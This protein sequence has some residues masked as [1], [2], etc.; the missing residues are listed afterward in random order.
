[1][2]WSPENLHPSVA[3]KD[4]S[5][6]QKK[7]FCRIANAMLAKGID[8][9]E[10]IATATKRVESKTNASDFP[11]FYYAKHMKPGLA[12]YDEETILVDNDAIKNM[13]PTMNGRPVYI[14]HND[15]DLETMKSDASGYVTD[16]FYNELDGCAWCKIMI[17]DDEAHDVIKKNWSVSNAY[18]PMQHEGKGTMHNCP[19]D[20]KILNGEFTHLALVPNPRYEDACIMTPDEFKAYQEVQKKQIDELRNSKPENNQEIKPMLKFFRTAREEISNAADITDD[21]YIEFQGKR[22]TIGDLNEILNSK[23]T[24][25]NDEDEKAGK[26]AKK[27]DEK[28][29]KKSKKNAEPKKSE[30]EDDEDEDDKENEVFDMD[31]EDVTMNDMKKAWGAYKKNRKENE[32]M[33][34]DDDKDD[35]ESD[36]DDEDEDGRDGGE[37][38]KKDE[39]GHKNKKNKKEKKNSRESDHFNDIRNAH[40]KQAFQTEE[41][42]IE[43]AQDKLARGRKFFGL[44][45]K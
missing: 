29:N 18:T 12:K 4:W 41:R 8:E 23:K 20:R 6:S 11:Q 42:E 38:R 17:I 22:I 1:M 25:M 14:H 33:D 39:E 27:E 2:P 3:K 37:N 34:E 40:M 31:G 7:E 45:K 44:D 24:K 28:K 10:V 36:E 13:I 43:T 21:S 30:K 16:S 35:D 26:H 15:V 19:Y 32:S 5:E 9:G